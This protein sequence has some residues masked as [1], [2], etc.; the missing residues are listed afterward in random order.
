MGKFLDFGVLSPQNPV[1]MANWD[2][3]AGRRA[4]TA[5]DVVYRLLKEQRLLGKAAMLAGMDRK[6]FSEVLHRENG[7]HLGAFLAAL[8]I[9]KIHPAVFF[10]H[11]FDS[12][13]QGLAKGELEGSK[14]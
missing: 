9:L 1:V 4:A 6:Y 13:I 5:A 8:E 2:T 10:K 7:I 12:T 14:T 3:K 11:Y